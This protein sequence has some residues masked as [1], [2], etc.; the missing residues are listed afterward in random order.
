MSEPKNLAEEL[1]KIYQ[2]AWCIDFVDM[3]HLCQYLRRC[4]EVGKCEAWVYIDS[5]NQY[6]NVASELDNLGFNVEDYN[7]GG[8]GILEITW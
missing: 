8:N 5:K 3:E 2:D 1:N 6:N 7:G 4:S